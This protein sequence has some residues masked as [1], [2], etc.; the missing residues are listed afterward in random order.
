M[1]RIRVEFSKGEAVRFLSHLDL[2]KAFE[3]AVRRAGIPIAFF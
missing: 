1:C 3:R 2:L